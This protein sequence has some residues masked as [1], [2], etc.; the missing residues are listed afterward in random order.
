MADSIYNNITTGWVFQA[1]SSGAP[2]PPGGLVLRNVAHDGHN[3]AKSLR[4]IGIWVELQEVAPSGQP[5]ATKKNFYLLDATSFAVGAAMLLVPTANPSW[6]PWADPYK[7]KESEA[8]L[9]FEDYL[10]QDGGS[11]QVGISAKYDA[12]ALFTSSPNC[13]DAG[14]TVEQIFLFSR[15][16]NNPRHEPSGALAAARCFPLIR[17]QIAKNARCDKSKTYT[18]VG[19]IRFD[20]RLHLFL[21][22]HHDLAAANIIGNLG[23]QAGLFANSDSLLTSAARGAKSAAAQFGAWTAQQ[24]YWPVPP[25]MTGGTATAFSAASFDAAEKPLPLEVTAPGLAAGFPVFQTTL[26]NGSLAAIRAWDNI[27]W[28]GARGS[29]QP[30]IS[31]PGAFHCA[32]LHWRWGGAGKATPAALTSRFNPNTYPR[33]LQIPQGNAG[34]WG[35]LVDPGIFTQNLRIAVTKN[36]KNLD[37]DQG[38]A[39]SAMSKSDWRTAFDS[40]GVPDKIYDG[41]DLVM[42]Y[43]IE[44]LHALE[45]KVD[46]NPPFPPA[47]W[48]AKPGGV[49][50]IHGIFFAHDAEQTGNTV[51]TT[52]PIY[53]PK[54]RATIEAQHAWLRAAQVL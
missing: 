42:W 34:L 31:S 1:A 43:S 40:G 6:A 3:F 21:D 38:A 9:Q 33:G 39:A 7:L 50:F 19:S 10:T 49:V 28:W 2:P 51:G 36:R 27:H 35:P 44:V 8:A 37:P 18:R 45:W 23:N 26:A 15:Y 46:N 14:L 5:G 12:P 16:S 54:D 53:V 30:L 29:G 24:R 48:T 11:Y 25:N 47:T 22:A 20:Y 32:H 41:D 13:E 52:A 4:L 17:Y